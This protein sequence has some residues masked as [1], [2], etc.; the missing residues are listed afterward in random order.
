MTVVDSTVTA[1]A[2]IEKEEDEEEEGLGD[3]M[4]AVGSERAR[5]AAAK[6]ACT[7]LPLEVGLMELI[8]ILL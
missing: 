1:G 3:F 2:L 4:K 5:L 6:A 8:F 7:R